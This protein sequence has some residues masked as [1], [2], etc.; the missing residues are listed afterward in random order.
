MYTYEKILLHLQAIL[1]VMMIG[2]GAVTAV[3]CVMNDSHPAYIIGSLGISAVAWWCLLRP[4]IKDLKN[5]RR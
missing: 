2:F 3:R 1:A 4:T 5:S